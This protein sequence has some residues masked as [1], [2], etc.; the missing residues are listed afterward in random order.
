MS[1]LNPCAP[2]WQMNTMNNMCYLGVPGT[3]SKAAA[4][5]ACMVDHGG[6]RL[7]NPADMGEVHF[8]N[9]LFSLGAWFWVGMQRD[10]NGKDQSWV[11]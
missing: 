11:F 7:V 1:A 8:I 4:E 10:N 3:V 9:S 2:G 6:A 5:E